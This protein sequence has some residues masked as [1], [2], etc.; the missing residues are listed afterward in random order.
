MFELYPIRRQ[1]KNLYL[2]QFTTT[3]N[4]HRNVPTKPLQFYDPEKDLFQFTSLCG[5]SYELS[6]ALP[7][8]LLGL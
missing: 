3:D 4:V 2:W 1:K 6:V 5:L 7:E 8:N